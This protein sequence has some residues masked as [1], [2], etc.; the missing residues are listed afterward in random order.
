MVRASGIDHDLEMTTRDGVVLRADVIRP[1]IEAKVPAIVARTPYEKTNT[2]LTHRYLPP[3]LAAQRGFAFVVQD[4]RGRYASEGEWDFVH[5]LEANVD[6]GYDTIEWVASQPWCDGNVG[7]E[8]GSYVGVTQLSAAIAEPPSLRAIAP[9]LLGVSESRSMSHSLPLE[10]MTVGWMAGLAVDLL[11]KNMATGE[12]SSSDLDRVM[13]AIRRPAVESATLPLERLLTLETPGMP[14]FAQ[15]EELVGAT[16]TFGERG[17][18]AITVP[19]LWTSGWYDNAGGGERFA[20][21]R[22][23][24]G[25]DLA[26][27]DSRLILGAWTHN[28]FESFV[29]ELG[30]GGFGSAAGGLVPESHL[31]YY[32]RHLRGED[33]DI[34][35]VRYFVIGP[36]E[37]KEGDDWP[38]PTTEAERWYL[39]SRGRANSG[40]GDG[41]LSRDEPSASEPADHFRYDPHDPVPSWGFRVMYTGGTTTS[42]PYEQTRVERRD[43]VLVYTSAPLTEPLEIVGDIELHLWVASSA[44]DTD[45][46]AKLCT[47]APDGTSVNLADG[48]LRARLR[49]GWREP[50]LL[51][52][53]EEVELVLE[54]GPV[55]YRFEPGSRIRIQVTSSAFPHLVRNMN[56]GNA[57]GVDEHG[58]VAEQTVLHDAAHPSSI[59]LPVQPA[60]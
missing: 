8:G 44:P 25:S 28:Y 53:G 24:A 15:V 35:V 60:A 12:A 55:G 51:E 56:T 47:V 32:S 4:I 49:E 2:M 36:N 34:P 59:V 33:V 3:V 40:G 46:V 30:L 13:E 31:T 45:F 20:E 38:L 27:R 6:D 11:T 1:D 52:P 7:M 22:Q 9:S 39:H 18:E 5:L 17:I 10:S 58:V 19:A 16:T 48:F 57:I 54:L 23:R 14:T 37:W 42:G 50:R 41:A 29:G 26:R 43:D 21:M